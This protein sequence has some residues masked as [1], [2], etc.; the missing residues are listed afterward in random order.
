MEDEKEFVEV[1]MEGEKERKM[2]EKRIF[3]ARKLLCK[4]LF[5]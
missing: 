5:N 1:N 2:K 4:V 3:W